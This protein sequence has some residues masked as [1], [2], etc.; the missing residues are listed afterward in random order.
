V[1]TRTLVLLTVLALAGCKSHKHPDINLAN[2]QPQSAV[3]ATAMVNLGMAEELL[4]R[5]IGNAMKDAEF[6]ADCG[7]YRDLTRLKECAARERCAKFN[8]D[9]NVTQEKVGIVCRMRGGMLAQAF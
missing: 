5:C 1:L 9:F 8:E 6:V 4:S 3:C 7:G 2:P